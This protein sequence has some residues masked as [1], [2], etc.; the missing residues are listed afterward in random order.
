LASGLA[1][2][3]DF[4]WIISRQQSNDTRREAAQSLAINGLITLGTALLALFVL[5]P[6]FLHNLTTSYRE[7]YAGYRSA[8]LVTAF[9]TYYQKY[10]GLTTVIILGAG[11]YFSTCVGGLR[12]VAFIGVYLASGFLLFQRTQDFG[13]QHWYG[14]MPGLC[15]IFMAGVTGL[16]NLVQSNRSK[17]SVAGLVVAVLALQLWNYTTPKVSQRIPFLR[18]VFLTGEFPLVRSDLEEFRRMVNTLAELQVS[19]EKVYVVASSDTLN[20]EMVRNATEQW[21]IGSRL[22]KDIQFTHEV[23]SRDGFPGRFFESR[24]IVVASPVQLHL[25]PGAQQNVSFLIDKMLHDNNF[26][27]RFEHLQP[28]FALEHNVQ[29]SLYRLKSP[30]SHDEILQLL[31]EYNQKKA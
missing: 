17:M 2:A 20:A 8:Q 31:Q 10:L 3:F 11:L 25:A 22:K 4:V 16:L 6:Q 30:F 1:I 7:L 13:C 19:D 28:A 9:H 12:R 23:D 18:S 24:L 27:D 15:V 14:L 5:S 21:S 26:R 29:V